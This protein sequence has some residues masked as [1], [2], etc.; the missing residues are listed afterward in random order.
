MEMIDRSSSSLLGPKNSGIM[1]SRWSPA[2]R[3]TFEE[4]DGRRVGAAR[5]TAIFENAHLY[6]ASVSTFCTPIS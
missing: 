2:G 6:R 3:V 1:S 5:E 4:N